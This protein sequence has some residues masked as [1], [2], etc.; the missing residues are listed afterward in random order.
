MK[1]HATNAPA[2]LRLL[3]KQIEEG[4]SPDYLLCIHYEDEFISAHYAEEPFTLLGL[5]D[6]RRNMLLDEVEK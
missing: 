4:N 6:F 2:K 1:L 3:A 5:V